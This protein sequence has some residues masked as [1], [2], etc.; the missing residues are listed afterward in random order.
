MLTN[1]VVHAADTGGEVGDGGYLLHAS[2]ILDHVLVP[3][4][5][6]HLGLL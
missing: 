2:N 5:G 3:G 4:L 6:V 1:H